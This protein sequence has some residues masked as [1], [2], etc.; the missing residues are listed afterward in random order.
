MYAFFGNKIIYGSFNNKNQSGL[1]DQIEIS[2]FIIKNKA[3]YKNN[4][5]IYKLFSEFKLTEDVPFIKWVG[6]SYENKFYKIHKD[7]MIY[8]G[9]DLL[10]TDINPFEVD[11]FIM[12]KKT[13]DDNYITRFKN[14]NE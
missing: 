10:K 3:P 5:D 13:N 7:S 6:S 12:S 14:E 9:Y 8:E 11:K 4:V 1:C 2:Y